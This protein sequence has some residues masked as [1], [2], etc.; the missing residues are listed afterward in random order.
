MFANPALNDILTTPDSGAYVLTRTLT[1]GE[2][3]DALARCQAGEASC[4]FTLKL[5]EAHIERVIQ[6]L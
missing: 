3:L 1:R 2:M 6:D 5:F 4:L